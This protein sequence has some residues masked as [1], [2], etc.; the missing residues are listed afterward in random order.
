M[1]GILDDALEG[2]SR[3]ELRDRAQNISDACR[4]DGTSTVIRGDLDA[5]RSGLQAGA[6]GRDNARRMRGSRRALIAA[7]RAVELPLNV[8]D[9]SDDGVV[10]FYERRLVLV[11]PDGHVAWRGNTV[12]AEPRAII[13]RIRASIAFAAPDRG[14]LLCV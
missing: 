3:K 13:D 4:S 6:R 5:L 7:A 1:S 2:V 11:R 12:P 8:A 9:V 10:R 14:R